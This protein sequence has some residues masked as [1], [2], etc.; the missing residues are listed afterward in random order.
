MNSSISF[1]RLGLSELTLFKKR[2][3]REYGLG[4]LNKDDFEYMNKR[5][6]DLI[7]RIDQFANQEEIN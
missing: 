1:H 6:E 7:C 4:S 5:I 2:L 3:G